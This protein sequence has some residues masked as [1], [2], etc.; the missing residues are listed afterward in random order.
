MGASEIFVDTMAHGFPCRARIGSKLALVQEIDRNYG[1]DVLNRLRNMALI[2]E[3]SED[4]CDSG[5]MEFRVGGK[6]LVD[7]YLR[8]FPRHL[9]ECHVMDVI[10][11]PDLKLEPVAPRGVA[12]GSPGKLREM[13]AARLRDRKLATK[14]TKQLTGQPTMI[15]VAAP[16]HRP[17]E[18]LLSLLAAALGGTTLGL[19]TIYVGERPRFYLEQHGVVIVL[20]DH[21][22]YKGAYARAARMSAD[23]L[24]LESCN[25]YDDVQTALQASASQHVIFGIA[26]SDPTDVLI[27]LTAAPETRRLAH[28]LGAILFLD[29]KTMKVVEMTQP[30]RDAV[31]TVEPQFDSCSDMNRG[32][33]GPGPRD[34]T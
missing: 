10:R 27:H 4:G 22:S 24:V 28:R 8:T 14:V 5:R 3:R 31:V 17:R 11:P 2:S 13:L 23:Y 34:F 9:Y 29:A 20:A 18:T 6:D 16:R 25:D 1:S 26:A 19:R 32:S 15:A 12:S 33:G 30:L 7:I 21:R